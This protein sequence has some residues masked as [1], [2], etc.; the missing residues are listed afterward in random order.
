[1]HADD[2]PVGIAAARAL[3]S[4]QFPDLAA[5]PL[6]PVAGFGTDN[7]IFRLGEGLALRFPRTAAAAPLP[8][9]EHRWL[10]A[11]APLLP[12]PLPRPVA[13]GRPGA[14]YPW[15]WTVAHWLPGRD[16]QAAPPDQMQAA[17]DL[18]A[19]IARLHALPVPADAPPMPDW[20]HI[21]PRDPF[22]RRMIAAFA[23]DEGDPARLAAE[24]S[25][26]LDLPRWRGR[27]VW[28]H[29]DLHPLNLLS[30][31][32]RLTGILDWGALSAGD[33]AH[34]LAAGWYLFDPQARAL[35][36]DLLAPDPAAWSRA[37]ALAL[38]K[39]VQAIPYYR[40]ANPPFRAAMQATLARVLADGA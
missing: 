20:G 19:F 21:A 9:R 6:R 37:R 14:G 10:P 18:A 16:A 25:A 35:F 15:R 3:I 28:T 34:D 4:A 30:D 12:L 13:L 7:V 32:R 17:R 23:A 5:L 2:R 39:A 1:M 27:P 8:E 33:P 38:S 29:A 22:M 11:L 31:G 40:T 36:R 24:W 26:A